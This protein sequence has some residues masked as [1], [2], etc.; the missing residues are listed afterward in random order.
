MEKNKILN[1]FLKD[2]DIIYDSNSF[3][4]NFI[5]SLTQTLKQNQ[6]ANIDIFYKKIYIKIAYRVRNG[7]SFA[8][9]DVNDF[10]LQ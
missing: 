9:W 8:K 6:Y 3:S 5:Y 1:K 7:D 4:K 10:D 2:S